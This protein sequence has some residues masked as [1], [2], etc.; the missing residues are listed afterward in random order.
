MEP[1]KL[2]D[3]EVRE[4]LSSRAATLQHWR[5]QEPSQQKRVKNFEN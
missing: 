2:L 3:R 1:I 5:E 4:L